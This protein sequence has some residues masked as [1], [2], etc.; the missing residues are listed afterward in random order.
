MIEDLA[1]R[2]RTQQQ[3]IEQGSTEFAVPDNRQVNLSYAPGAATSIVAT[4]KG[5][6]TAV[7]FFDS[8]GQPWPIQWDTNSNPS[9]TASAGSCNPQNSGAGPSVAA[10]GFFV[11]APTKGGNV[12]DVTPMSFS[13]RGSLVVSLEGSPKPFTFL[14]MPGAGR[15]DASISVHVAERGPR[16]KAEIMT[17]SGAPETGAAF[18]TGMLEGVPPSEAVP[19]SVEGVS[20]EGLRAWRLGRNVYLRTRYTL[21]S[22]EWTASEA[23]AGTTVYAVPNTPVVLLS[24]NGRT[25][26]AQ[27]KE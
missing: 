26:S 6:T 20:P 13:P 9:A 1:R 27:L 24:V 18:L 2:Y 22:P 10:V 25:V 3:A 17:Q 14:L 19:L 23:E 7:S 11:C 16:A 12:L 8:T 21:L 4:M 15:Y 5:Y